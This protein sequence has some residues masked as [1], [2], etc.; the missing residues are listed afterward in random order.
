MGGGGMLKSWEPGFG[1]NFFDTV[2]YLASNW[3]LPLGGLLISVYAGWVM[4][5]KMRDAELK[6]AAPAL[7]KAWLLL[8]RFVAP[9]LVVLVL[10][11][12]VG[13]IELG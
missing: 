11:Q 9:V 1:K 3:M 7:T 8:V 2:D 10:L 13:F 5:A 4:P 12:K 6:G